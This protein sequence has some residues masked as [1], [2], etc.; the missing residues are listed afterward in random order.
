MIIGHIDGMVEYEGQVDASL[1]FRK[2]IHRYNTT[3]RWARFGNDLLLGVKADSETNRS[4]QQFLPEN[5]CHDFSDA[6]IV[7]NDGT[8]RKLIDSESG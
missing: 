5:L 7:S 2:L 4:E 8:R 6:Q 3:H 1:S